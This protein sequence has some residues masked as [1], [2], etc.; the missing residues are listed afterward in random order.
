M[1]PAH[2]MASARRE[3][4]DLKVSVLAAALSKHPS[5]FVKPRAIL[6]TPEQLIN[7]PPSPKIEKIEMRD[8]DIWKW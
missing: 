3:V 8:L 6:S 7:Y 2:E 4:Q 5:Y 1:A